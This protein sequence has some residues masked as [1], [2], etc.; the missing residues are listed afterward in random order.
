MSSMEEGGKGDAVVSE[1]AGELSMSMDLVK[2]VV[3]VTIVAACLIKD[4]DQD[5]IRFTTNKFI[6]CMCL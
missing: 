6:L 5:K 2:P 4:S 3:R 1:E